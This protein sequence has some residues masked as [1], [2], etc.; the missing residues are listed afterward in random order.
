MAVEEGLEDGAGEGAGAEQRPEACGMECWTDEEAWIKD[1]LKR[2]PMYSVESDNC[3][4]FAYEFLVW[5]T[6]GVFTVP[7]R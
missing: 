6:D 4:K 7:H 2:N 1:W 5:L 3:Q